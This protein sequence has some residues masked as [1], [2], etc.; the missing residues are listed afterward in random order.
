MSPGPGEQHLNT[1]VKPGQ[2]GFHPDH[3][4]RREFVVQNLNLTV[5]I[6]AL[7]IVIYAVVMSWYSWSDE[8]AH[9]IT[10]LTTITELESKAFDSYFSRLELDLKA[11]AENLTSKGELIDLDQAFEQ[12]RKFN[13]FR[14]E[15]YNVTLIRPDGLILLTAKNPPGTTQVSL[16]KE[17]SFTT[18]INEL[19]QGTNLGIGQPLVGA[20]SKVAIVPVRYV[21]RDHQGQLSFILS[22]NLPHEHLR[23]FWMD[24]PIAS[25][26]AIGLMRDNGFLLSRYPVPTSSTLAQVYGQPRTGALIQH[27]QKQGFP[28]SGH[29]E[30][31]SSLDGPDF[32]NVF[33]RLPNHP[34]TLFIAMPMSEIQAQW[35]RRVSG[36]YLVLF[37]LML[38]GFAAYRYALRR[39]YAWNVEQE[40]LEEVTRESEQRFRHLISHNNAIILQIEPSSGRILDANAAAEKFYGWSHDELCQMSIQDINQMNPEQVAVERQAAALEQRNYFIF[41]HRL[42][43]GEIRTVEV[44]STPINHAIKAVLVSIIHDI[45]DRVRTEKQVT[46]LLQEQK[47]IL[48]S[49]LVGI[50]KIKDRQFVWFND[51]FAKMMGYSRE[52]LI[53]QPTRIVYPTDQAYAEFATAAYPAMQKGEVFRTEI[54]YRRKDGSL[55]WYELAGGMIYP[56]SA[57]SIW[58]FIDINDRKRVEAELEQHR[59]HL[60][61]LVEDRTTALSIAREAAEAASRA[62]SMFLGNISHELRTPMNGIMGMTG[63][64]LRRVTDPKTSELLGIAMASAEKL[65]LLLNNLIDISKME[66]E[67]FTLERDRFKMETVLGNLQDHIGQK[68]E[69]KGVQF[70][71]DIA[72]EVSEHALLGDPVRLGQVLATLIE[73]AIKFTDDG[74]V[75]VRAQVLAE[76]PADIRLRFEVQDTG[77]G[78]AADDQRRLF[79]LFEQVDGSLNRKYGGTGLGLVICKRLIELMG[80]SIG[81]SSQIG[82]GSTFWF[83]ICLEKSME[84]AALVRE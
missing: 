32:L 77:I 15:L 11:L 38:G 4:M 82:V 41:Q 30:G 57:E 9:A 18:F 20:V 17:V 37:F 52:E 74:S 26:A 19:K 40:R 35:W 2:P 53:G 45:S 79:K 83:D 68:A 21:I 34:V 66:A 67:R 1:S 84:S 55:G 46:S 39:Q 44:H 75:T 51:A 22:A 73:N 56:D 61:R 58:S 7:L 80:G 62:K 48:N 42:A 65:L 47:A 81:V 6:L 10:N 70:I 16:A 27:L 3:G 28:Q 33:H 76:T 8:K 31:P 50:V 24:A 63:V 72:P 49:D 13:E 29:V 25:K 43:N 23:S 69:V 71:L 12:V 60:E 54:Q 36:S 64:A 78:I 59:H 14:P 5:V